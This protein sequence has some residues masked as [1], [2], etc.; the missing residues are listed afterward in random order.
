VEIVPPLVS[1][2]TE[3]FNGCFVSLGALVKVPSVDLLASSTALVIFEVNTPFEVL[4]KIIELSSGYGFVSVYKSANYVYCRQ[5][6][7]VICRI[8]LKA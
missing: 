4:W 5:V 3:E 6:G 2:D 1:I 7:F 8:L